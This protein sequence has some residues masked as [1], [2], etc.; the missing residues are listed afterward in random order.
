VRKKVTKRPKPKPISVP[1]KPLLQFDEDGEPI[2]LPPYIRKQIAG[3]DI[4]ADFGDALLVYG[5]QTLDW[6]EFHLELAPWY[7]FEFFEK[8]DPIRIRGDGRDLGNRESWQDANGK[9]CGLAFSP[10]QKWVLRAAIETAIG[11]GFYLALMRYADDLKSVP[12]VAAIRAAL[13]RGRKKGA[14]TVRKK[15]APK[16]MAIRK[17]FRELRK[18]GFMKTDARLLI[19]QETGISFRQIERDTKGLS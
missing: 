3:I 5:E 14:D 9:T 19:E 12:E 6:F 1:A 15:A 2:E 18:S 10:Q 13:E 8:T 16:K 4:P 17:R 11:Q 7:L